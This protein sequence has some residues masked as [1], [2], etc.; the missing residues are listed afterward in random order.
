MKKILLVLALAASL[1]GC[2]QMKAFGQG[3]CETQTEISAG[4]S[5]IGAF[6][7]TPGTIFTDAFN[8]I[9]RTGCR[10]FAAT[11]ALPQEGTD[12]VTEMFA[13]EE[14]AEAP[15]EDDPGN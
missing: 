1:T 8:I 2:A 14:P 10:V 5:E 6:F 15:V 4:I 11:M 3:V 7:G 13:D 9:L 12:A